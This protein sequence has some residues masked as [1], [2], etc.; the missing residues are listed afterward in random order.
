MTK[1]QEASL[2]SIKDRFVK[3]VDKKYRKGQKEHGGNLWKKNGLIDMAID[4]AVD[5]VVYLIYLRDQI[6]DLKLTRGIQL[7]TIDDNQK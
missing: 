7:G 6:E 5:Q 4:E 2:Q 3:W 1:Q